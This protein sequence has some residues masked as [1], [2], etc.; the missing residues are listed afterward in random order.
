MGT[1]WAV[2]TILSLLI[3]V[4]I[5]RINIKVTGRDDEFII[6]VSAL[7]G[8]VNIKNELNLIELLINGPAGLNKRGEPAPTAKGAMKESG[9]FKY[10]EKALYNYR[11]YSAK[12]K[13]YKNVVKYL[14]RKV[15]IKRLKWHT[16]LGT[17]D[18]AVTGIAIGF[19]WH[20]KTVVSTLLAMGF[21][22]RELPDLGIS[23]CFAEPAFETNF[24]CIL[25]IRIGHAITAA[26]LYLLTAKKKDGDAIERAS[27]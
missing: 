6:V 2:L 20:I 25:S 18:A 13:R 15:C 24:N 21:K 27:D 5:S 7:Y 23:P 26:I 17:G 11:E 14:E 16:V 12:A 10:A 1:G 8:L 19:L 22:L 3:I 4:L 9:Y